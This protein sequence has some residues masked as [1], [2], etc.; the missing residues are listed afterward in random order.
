MINVT[1]GKP[2]NE[3]LLEYQPVEISVIRCY[4]KPRKNKACI[5]STKEGEKDVNNIRQ[6]TLV[7][8]NQF[9]LSAR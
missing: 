9:A 2:D 1:N 7:T 6:S 3:E 8:L 4:A 5:A